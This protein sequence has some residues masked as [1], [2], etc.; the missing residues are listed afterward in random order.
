MKPILLTLI[1]LFSFINVSY[2][3]YGNTK[4]GMSMEEVIDK[5]N[6]R[7]IEKGDNILFYK[8]SS[9]VKNFIINFNFMF[10][11]GK[12]SSV[13]ISYDST[14]NKS[15][16]VTRL[17]NSLKEFFVD[18]FGDPNTYIDIG[19]YTIWGIDNTNISLMTM[20]DDKLKSIIVSYT[21]KVK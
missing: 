12:L 3:Q 21:L 16:E 11:N 2:S 13:L 6:I 10:T 17:Y 8:D 1:I 15:S 9:L 20:D 19:N 7:N 5:I 4:W 18:K 14:L